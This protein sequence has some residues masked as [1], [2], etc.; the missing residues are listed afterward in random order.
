MLFD[1]I[2]SGLQPVFTR[3]WIENSADIFMILF[4]VNLVLFGGTSYIIKKN[5]PYA[6]AWSIFFMFLGLQSVLMGCVF[7]YY[8][9][10]TQSGFLNNLIYLLS[11]GS[12]YV[13]WMS[14]K[15][16]L[17]SYHKK[18]VNYLLYLPVL[19]IL[20]AGV[21]NE[22]AALVF[23][24]VFALY[25]YVEFY[26][27]MKILSKRAATI[28]KEYICLA[29][30][31]FLDLS[32]VY[33][34]VF[35]PEFC[36]LKNGMPD[37][38]MTFVYSK[39]ILLALV[40]F[41]MFS[42]YW[43][44]FVNGK[45]IYESNSKENTAFDY[46]II[47]ALFLTQFLGI[48]FINYVS[49]Q[50]NKEMHENLLSQA[51]IMRVR[52]EK[53][54]WSEFSGTL[55]DVK[56]PKYFEIS[57]YLKKVNILA[58][59][60][61]DPSIVIKRDGVLIQEMDDIS[62]HNTG[63][64]KLGT[65]Q[66]H[67]DSVFKTQKEL[68]SW[69]YFYSYQAG[70]SLLLPVM[71]KE[72][73]KVQAVLCMKLNNELWA[74]KT[75]LRRILAS[76]IV[77]LIC[78]L[79]SFYLV[80]RQKFKENEIQARL[81]EKRL[82]EAQ[83]IAGIGGFEYDLLNDKLI[84][85]EE[86]Y[87]IHE[88]ESVSNNI[89]KYF[90]GMLKKS[91]SEEM[92]DSFSMRINDCISQMREQEFDYKI[93]TPKGH[94][95]D[96]NL[97]IIP[98]HNLQGQII[99]LIGTVQDVTVQKKAQKALIDAKNAAEE[100]NRTKSIFLANMSHEIRTPMNA[101]LGYS[102]LMMD[103]DELDE[104]TREKS[105]IIYNSGKHLLGVINGILEMSK[106]EAG[107]IKV[108][109]A[110]M[111]MSSFVCDV[112]YIFLNKLLEKSIEFEINTNNLPDIVFSDEDKLRQIAINLISNATKFTKNGKIVWDLDFDTEN[113]LLKM[114]IQDTGCGIAHEDLA[115]IFQ[116]FEQSDAGKKY[117]G[118]GL[119]LSIT[120]NLVELLNGGI[121][122]ESYVNVGTKFSVKIPVKRFRNR[123]KADSNA[124]TR[125]VGLT[126]NS[127]HSKILVVDDSKENRDVLVE[128][129]SGAGFE[130][131]QANDGIEA[132]D[133]LNI[134]NP[135]LIFMDVRMPNMDGLTASKIIKSTEEYKHIPIIAVTAG[136]FSSD[137][138]QIIEAGLDSYI[139]KP[140]ENINVLETV[141]KYLCVEYEYE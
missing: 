87:H 61:I 84:C 125:I 120:K 82:K 99:S 12:L 47:L 139:I 75:I 77:V 79:L 54:D 74:K 1:T 112:K 95:K 20:M 98:K 17:S 62:G 51:R 6:K 101:I 58:P 121:K 24:N 8:Y 30:W 66:K 89:E 42:Y 68:I 59:Q 109:T 33:V 53:Y 18:T 32:L 16:A 10:S 50:G 48:F 83:R 4:A 38:A 105:Y 140:F 76:S 78:F 28:N 19:F 93:V 111:D 108:S 64:M 65:K 80:V 119:G 21:F 138:E 3:R 72:S 15:A 56:N 135:E 5:T 131:A 7:Y 45:L 57:E 134:F 122:V 132:L 11:A 126:K 81:N 2:V 29:I 31:L 86:I 22:T 102:Q 14:T 73:S 141:R 96:I 128:I 136:A 92:T 123:E 43:L 88:T 27:L 106:I 130:V 9:Y 133:L 115:N 137:T 52:L 118:T 103:N 25:C 91:Y 90:H 113:S 60:F 124:R 23:R 41:L 94:I 71:E 35:Y 70:Y 36:V 107:H 37:F 26:K 129:L 97:K 34:F 104:R 67:I 44:G 110:P 117:G 39:S 49:I 116:P 85:S 100:A 127:R 13:F 46:F 40:T 69:D 114:S 63:V 55:K